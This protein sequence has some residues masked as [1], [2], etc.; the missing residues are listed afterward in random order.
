MRQLNGVL[1]DKP[2]L[3]SQTF[4]LPDITAVAGLAFADFAKIDILADLANLKAWP[5]RVAARSSAVNS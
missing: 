3:A 5:E 2:N 4:I 1:E